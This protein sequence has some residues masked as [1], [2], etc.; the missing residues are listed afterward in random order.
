MLTTF[1]IERPSFPAT[2]P[3]N[4]D[5][6]V[7]TPPAMPRNRPSRGGARNG[8][9]PCSRR[10]IPCVPPGG[11]N[12][13]LQKR[14]GCSGGPA[15][16]R[17]QASPKRLAES[18]NHVGGPLVVVGHR[19]ERPRPAA[20]NDVRAQPGDAHARTIQG[21][22]Q[23]VEK[24]GVGYDHVAIQQHQHV[25]PHRASSSRARRLRRDSNWKTG[26]TLSVGR[27]GNGGG[28]RGCH[29]CSRCRKSTIPGRRRAPMRAPASG[30]TAGPRDG[31]CE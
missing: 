18:G 12:P 27:G 20:R 11:R 29:P 17:Q 31:D 13:C 26:R 30:N 6:S 4:S 5:T 15:A 24:R 8:P 28:S 21:I 25:A 22:E 14:R 2:F 16:R 23:P 1:R 9:A 7:G 19:F 3:R 10:S